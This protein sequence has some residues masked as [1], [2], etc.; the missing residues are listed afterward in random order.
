[1]SK[2]EGN[3]LVTVL[4]MTAFMASLVIVLHER[5]SASYRGALD[6]QADNQGGIYAGTAL[7]VLR[8]LMEFDD[9]EYDAPTDQWTVI[10]P[11]PVRGGF[12][13]VSVRPADSRLP[14]N[15]LANQDNATKKR[16]EDAFEYMYASLEYSDIMWKSLRDWVS[17]VSG[18]GQ[19][20]IRGVVFNAEGNSYM[21]KHG[22]LSSLYEIRLIP[23]YPEVYN[24]VVKYLSLGELEPKINI[25]FADNLTIRAFLP[26]L[27]TYVDEIIEAREKEPLKT[28]DALYRILGNT[29]QELY[30]KVLPF[31]DVKSSLFYV[32]IEVNILSSTQYYHILMRKSGRRFIVIRYIEGRGID[33]F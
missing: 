13:S 27:T 18:P 15:A 32:K 7:T 16:M 31:F 4:I 8:T 25:N 5:S 1:M 28:K 21:A 33:Y 12:V 10:P 29:N 20:I 2:R 17:S 26:E 22:L 24:D 6:L 23:G 3:V 11:I 9:P 19:S 14:V 30:T